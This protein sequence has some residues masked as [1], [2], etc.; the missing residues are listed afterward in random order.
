LHQPG[1]SPVA[2]I[3]P[4]FALLV[5][6][7]SPAVGAN[8][9][10][11]LPLEFQIDIPYSYFEYVSIDAAA[12]TNSIVFDVGSNVTITTAFMTSSQFS[13]FND[14]QGEI[15]D[16]VYVQNGTSSQQTEH[17]P[18]GDYFLVFYAYQGNANVTYNYDLFPN[19]PYGA[20]PILAPEPGGIATFGLDNDSGNV[21]PY[22]VAAH[23][24]V[25]VADISSLLAQNSTAALANS[26]VSGATLQL[27]SVLV[28]KEKGGSQQVYW[29]QNTPDFVTSASQVADAD[30]LWNY[31]VSG[32]LSNATITSSNGGLAYSYSQGGQTQYYYGLELSN[33]TYALP[34]DLALAINETVSPGLGVVVEMGAQE[35]RNGSIPATPMDWFDNVTIHDPTVSGAYFYVSGNDT[36]PEGTFYDT[37]FVF[38]GENDGEATSF[39]QMSAS[40]QLFYDNS[41]DGALTYFPSYY[42]FGQDTAESADNLHVSYSDG[43]VQVSPGSVNYVYLGR[44]SGSSSLSQL[45]ASSGTTSTT[46]SVP[47]FPNE[48]LPMLALALVAV[49]A[50]VTRGPGRGA[51]RV[52]ST[53]HRDEATQRDRQR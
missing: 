19:S 18:E 10:P 53:P 36:T 13:A 26:T 20:G 52:N 11:T 40:M 8:R 29:A 28:V 6:A 31:S 30:N 24:V 1:V 17:V 2:S 4:L 42:S 38:G 47:E 23:E 12:G 49:V 32:F 35:L 7:V 21:T 43:V 5:V 9:S 34:L 15:A 33:S 46:T 37:E 25:G 50:L 27:N 16:S 45:A 14:S 39:S 3:L 22:D 41:T 44:A 51:G 48:S